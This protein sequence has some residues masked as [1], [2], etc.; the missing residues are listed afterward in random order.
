MYC[1]ALCCAECTS[2]QEDNYSYWK[3]DAVECCIWASRAAGPVRMLVADSKHRQQRAGG[4]AGGQPVH[5]STVQYSAEQLCWSISGSAVRAAASTRSS[6][7][8]LDSTR[9]DST[10]FRVLCSRG[11]RAAN[12]NLLDVVVVAKRWTVL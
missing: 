5:C 10:I 9:L 6:G 11:P 2:R 7:A 1:T 3:L 8:S 12:E 4:R